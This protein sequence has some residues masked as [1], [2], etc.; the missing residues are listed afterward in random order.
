MSFLAPA[1]GALAALAALIIVQ[2]FLKLR[3]PARTIPSTFL[4]QRALADTR[5]NAPWQRLRA[6]PL[7]IL[8]VLALVA[9][10]VALMRPYVLRAGAASENVV[11][12]LDAS[13]STQT[14]EG[15]HSRFAAEVAQLHTLI[16]NLPPDHTMSLIRMDRHPRV[17]IAASSDH[18][19][20]N[21]ALNSQQPGYDQ[22]DA[23]D[24]LA[25]AL[26]L[27]GQNQG[28]DPHT[29][30]EIFRSASTAVPGLQ[31]GATLQ[32]QVFGRAGAP[33]LGI[34]AF[35]AAKETDGSVNAITRVVN[36]GST[37]LTS[38]VEVRADG[39]LEDV[40]SVTVPPGGSQVVSSI[41]L[42]G[43]SRALQ[44]D[45]TAHDA[46]AAD[47]TAWTVIATG[48]VSRILLVTNGDL[49]LHAAL[50]GISNIQAVQTTPGAYTMA[51]AA[52]ADLV[53]FDG[54]LPR[55]LPA[56][57]LLLVAPPPT[58]ATSP[59]G[60]PTGKGLRP[61]DTPRL[62]DD[63][64]ALLRYTTP[65]NIHI[66]RTLDMQAPAWAH[67]ALRDSKGP[68]LLEAD[69]GPAG[70]GIGRIAVLGFSP[71]QS[72]LWAS[73]DFPVL[74]TNL[75]NWLTP[76]LNLNAANFSPDDVVH[77]GIAP[78]ASQATVQLPGGQQQSLFTPG[79]PATTGT[80]PFASTAQP[81]VYQISERIGRSKIQAAFSVNSE[82]SA[83]VP[84][85]NPVVATSSAGNRAGARSAASGHA[86]G[87]VP[88]E[89][90]SGVALLVLALLA[91]EWY[92]AMR[93]R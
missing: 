13:V 4:W 5:A 55:T 66:Y 48:S 89:L 22:P 65:A 31:A 47:N 3:R 36:T 24:A 33:N 69:Q 12:V 51:A 25:L 11:A 85:A 35:A 72:D 15:G 29:A 9:L 63:P 2:Y 64:A 77:I 45:L 90:T 6:D 68:L 79:T 54:W 20:L 71:D 7:L 46:L 19:A 91:A 34:A 26:G 18:G 82:A 44:A 75:L 88:V 53:I 56:T 83:L 86:Q 14:V 74:I 92:V 73:L 81:G 49:F 61:A 60:I 37:T 10:V 41:G 59:L 52:D 40:Q 93:R 16:D 50:A 57:N 70:T 62:D 27:A 21:S 80:V 39:K 23:Q 78:G 32:D 43:S 1:F 38:D 30:V 17:L 8:Q 42:P 58:I 84:A 67:V 28:G 76:G 87:Q